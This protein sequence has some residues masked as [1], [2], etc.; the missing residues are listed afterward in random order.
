MPVSQDASSV[1]N[2]SSEKP[3]GKTSPGN[4]PEVDSDVGVV[5]PNDEVFQSEEF[6]ALGW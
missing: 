4:V 3:R 5:A 2:D 6:R 1:H